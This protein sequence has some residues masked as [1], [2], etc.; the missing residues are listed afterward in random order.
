MPSLNKS[1]IPSASISF[2]KNVNEANS[3]STFGFVALLNA[4]HATGSPTY[5]QDLHSRAEPIPKF[6]PSGK[7]ERLDPSQSRN[8]RAILGGSNQDQ[9]AGSFRSFLE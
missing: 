2:S 3:I 5:C 7:F 6:H 8:G 1:L 4:D 9:H